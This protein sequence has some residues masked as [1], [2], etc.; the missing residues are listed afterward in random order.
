MSDY[1]HLPPG[2]KFPRFPRLTGRLHALIAGAVV[3]ILN[4]PLALIDGVEK[5]IAKIRGAK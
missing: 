1:D 4:F 5:L 3:I 2:A